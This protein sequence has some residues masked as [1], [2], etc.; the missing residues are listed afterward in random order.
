MGSVP[1]LQGQELK[2]TQRNCRR[3]RTGVKGRIEKLGLILV[4][5]EAQTVFNPVRLE[6]E[7]H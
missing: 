1:S 5:V 7:R 4:H 3:P 6:I 2:L